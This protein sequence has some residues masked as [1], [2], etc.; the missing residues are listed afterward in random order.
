MISVFKT[1]MILFCLIINTKIIYGNEM[2]ETYYLIKL[3]SMDVQTRVAAL[4]D[5]NNVLKKGQINLSENIKNTCYIMIDELTKGTYKYSPLDDD[6]NLYEREIVKLSAKIN[7]EKVLPFLLRHINDKISQ[8]AL[9]LQGERTLNELFKMTDNIGQIESNTSRSVIYVYTKMI[10]NKELPFYK[11]PKVR[12]DIKSKVIKILEVKKY[13][14]FKT[15]NKN[16]N[17]KIIAENIVNYIKKPALEFFRVL[18]DKDIIP[19]VEKMAKTDA[20]YEDVPKKSMKFRRMTKEDMPKTPAE[21]EKANAEVAAIGAEYNAKVKSNT[22]TSADVE[23]YYPVRE[24]AQKVLAEL[25][26]KYGLK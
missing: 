14:D 7:D 19:I 24:E 6:E 9:V 13:P 26:G 8:E 1:L 16:N 18:G 11:S 12:N 4:M 23:R 5:L 17:Q 21:V 20:Y 22:L 3:K 15:A 2:D 10:Q 25:K